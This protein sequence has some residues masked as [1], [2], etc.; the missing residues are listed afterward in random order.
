MTSGEVFLVSEVYLLCAPRL[1]LYFPLSLHNPQNQIHGRLIN[2]VALTRWPN[3]SKE[4]F[5]DP[6]LFMAVEYG[7][8]RAGYVGL[9]LDSVEFAG[10]DE[11]GD[12]RPVFCSD[13]V[14]CKERVLAAE[15]NRPNGSFDIVVV[16]LNAAVSEEETQVTPVFGDV[17]QGLASGD[18]VATPAG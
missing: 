3:N 13:V 17:V 16:Q 2:G 14:A 15:G 7:C 10:L 6:A 1:S 8:E 9:R 18:L 5:N 12:G 4:Q 11:R